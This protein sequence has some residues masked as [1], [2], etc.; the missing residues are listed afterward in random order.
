MR[1]RRE[2]M[3]TIKKLSDP[4]FFPYR[5]GHAFW[6]YVAGRWGDPAVGDMLRAAGPERK[7]RRGA[8]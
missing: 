4:D 7:H 8:R 2:K 5:Y 6:A 1:H 3:P